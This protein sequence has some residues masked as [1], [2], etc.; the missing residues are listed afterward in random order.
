MA[1][2]IRSGPNGNRPA[3]P[4]RDAI[5]VRDRSG[6]ATAGI[7]G[8]GRP[9]DAAIVDGAGASESKEVSSAGSDRE[10]EGRREAGSRAERNADRGTAAGAGVSGYERDSG[11]EGRAAGA[12][13][14]GWRAA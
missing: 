7:S 10:V 14:D 6:G 11:R 5:L 2:K 1:P 13:G 12:G 4:A 9:V 8:V 3:D